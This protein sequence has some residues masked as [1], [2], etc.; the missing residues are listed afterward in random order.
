MNMSCLHHH[1][2]Q[3]IIEKDIVKLQEIG[4]VVLK[5][6]WPRISSNYSTRALNLEKFTL[7]NKVLGPTGTSNYS[8][9]KFGC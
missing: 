5:S 7:L 3:L 6:S 8:I 2:V 4:P 9:D 1:S